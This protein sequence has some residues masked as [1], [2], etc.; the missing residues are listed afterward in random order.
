ML[1]TAIVIGGELVAPFK[2]ALAA[3]TGHHWVTKGVI[4]LV[5][6]AALTLLLGPRYSREEGQASAAPLS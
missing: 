5:V 2:S 6:F 1:I 3:I 4:E